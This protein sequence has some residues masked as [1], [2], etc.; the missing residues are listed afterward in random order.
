MR[1]VAT[2][3][4]RRG[5]L[6]LGDV[7]L[8]DRIQKRLPIQARAADNLRRQGLIE[9]RMPRLHI[10]AEIAAT[11]GKEESYLAAK[12]F[13]DL[14]YLHRVLQFLCMKGHATREQID[15]LLEKHLST[16]RYGL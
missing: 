15:G 13:D 1:V 4:E 2:E 14:F 9:G 6:S 8:L 5:D 7:C 3:M 16:T 10:S 11:G 12:G